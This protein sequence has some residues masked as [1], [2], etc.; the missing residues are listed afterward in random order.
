MNAVFARAATKAW[1]FLL[2]EVPMGSPFA[3]SANLPPGLLFKV[4]GSAF[5]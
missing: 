2:R 3:N 1:M 5:S 4:S